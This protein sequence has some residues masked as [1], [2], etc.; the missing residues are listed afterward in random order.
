ML[1]IRVYRDS[2]LVLKPLTIDD[3]EDF[4]KLLVDNYDYFKPSLM[5]MIKD[6]LYEQSLESLKLRIT[7]TFRENN[8]PLWFGIYFNGTLCGL[9]GFNELDVENNVG[10]LGYFMSQRQSSKGLMSQ[11]LSQIIAYSFEELALNKLELYINENNQASIRLA[12]KHGFKLEGTIREAVKVEDTYLNQHLYGLL[13][14][15]FHK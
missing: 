13:K 2:S 7:M 14:S 12:N 10:E 1:N 11:S 15:E 9:I 4:F 3:H 8:L 6:E 5:W